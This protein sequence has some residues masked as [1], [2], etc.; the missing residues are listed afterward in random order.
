MTDQQIEPW[1][2]WGQMLPP[3]FD[4]TV[5]VANHA[6]SGETI[7]SFVGERRF[8][9]VMSLISPGDYLFMQFGHNDC[10]K[11]G[12]YRTHR[13]PPPAWQGLPPSLHCRDL[14]RAKGAHPVLV[15]SME[16]RNF[17]SSGHIVPSLEGYPQAMREV[18]AELKVPVIDLNAMSIPFYES[19]GPE[20]SKKAFVYFPAD[21]FPGQP[22]ALAD[23]TSFQHLR[24][25]R[26]L[27]R[28]VVEGIKAQVRAGSSSE[29]RPRF[30]TFRS[31]TVPIYSPTGTCPPA[32]RNP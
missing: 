4:P 13:A 11:T 26:E 20:E 2:A 6:E 3:F 21:S 31:G 10:Q 8:D 15:T 27:A 29:K 23:D 1:G 19:L 9:K 30:K 12:Q 25:L 18:G 22:T 14:K 17:D 7:K 5:A 32:R 24:R 16:R 28:C